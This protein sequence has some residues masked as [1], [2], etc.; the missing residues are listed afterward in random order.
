MKGSPS[1]LVSAQGVP[2]ASMMRLPDGQKSFKIG[3]VLFITMPAVTDRQP[4][5]QPA[6]HVAVT[7]RG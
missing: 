2:N 1:N 4:A 7:S 5:S 3:L 6:S